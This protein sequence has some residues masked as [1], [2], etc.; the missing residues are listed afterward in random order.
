[1][2]FHKDDVEEVQRVSFIK[3][4]GSI[5]DFVKLLKEIQEQMEALLAPE[6]GH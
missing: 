6:A 3:K 5:V 1:M 4:Q 2:K